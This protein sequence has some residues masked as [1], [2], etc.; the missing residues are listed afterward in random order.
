ML[1]DAVLNGV[2]TLMASPVKLAHSDLE[3]ADAGPNRSESE[4]GKPIAFNH[5]F[6]NVQLFVIK[7][8][9]NW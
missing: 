8:T 1:S 9:N 5:L 2:L 6:R 4:L 3:P 7:C